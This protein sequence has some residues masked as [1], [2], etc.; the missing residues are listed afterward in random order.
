MLWSQ[1]G[2][3]KVELRWRLPHCYLEPTQTRRVTQQSHSDVARVLLT[4]K[5]K[6]A[7]WC[8]SGKLVMGITNPFLIRSEA[9]S[10]RRNSYLTLYKPDKTP[11][12]GVIGPSA[13]TPAV[14]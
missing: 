7:Y 12:P 14:F 8:N 10:T 4:S 2:E 5:T 6:L 11:Y 9:C 1:D 13:K 3:I